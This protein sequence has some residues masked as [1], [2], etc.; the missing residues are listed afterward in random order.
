MLRQLSYAIKN[1][2]G[3]RGFGTGLCLL[4]ACSLWHKRDR[5]LPCTERSY[6]LFY[7]AGSL[8]MISLSSFDQN[9]FN[10]PIIYIISWS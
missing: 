1:Q 3:H 4:I 7:M 9:D 10:F 8:E 6:Y 2:L 5:W